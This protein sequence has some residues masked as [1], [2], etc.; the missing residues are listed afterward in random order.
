M[1]YSKLMKANP[2][3]TKN[4]VVGSGTGTTAVT[5]AKVRL[6]K[7]K[8]PPTKSPV[9]AIF[10]IPPPSDR[11]MNSFGLLPG[12]PVSAVLV[13]KVD[14]MEPMTAFDLSKAVKV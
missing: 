2:V 1:R 12:S 5:G 14:A 9:M 13:E 4:T 6:S 3:P 8:E 10:D 7:T 11:P